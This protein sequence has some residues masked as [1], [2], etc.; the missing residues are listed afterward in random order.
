MECLG[1]KLAKRVTFDR[2]TSVIVKPISRRWSQIARPDYSRTGRGAELWTFLLARDEAPAQFEEH[3]R[4]E[5]V[6]ILR[7]YGRVDD[8][9]AFC[10]ARY[11][12]LATNGTSYMD[13]DEAEILGR[14]CRIRMEA[15]G[16]GRSA[17]VLGSM[18]KNEAED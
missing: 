7:T 17:S 15:M 9:E 18:I 2:I 4:D 6:H 5:K 11:L 13:A 14:D 10:R 1:I 16:T 12:P 8:A 3:F